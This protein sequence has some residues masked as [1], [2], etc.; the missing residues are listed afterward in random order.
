MDCQDERR[1]HPSAYKEAEHAVDLVSEA[2]WLAVTVTFA[3]R[4]DPQSG[5]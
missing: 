3:D 1:A 4:S 2:I 5:R